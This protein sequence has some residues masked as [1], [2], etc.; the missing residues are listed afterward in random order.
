MTWTMLSECFTT[1]VFDNSSPNN[2]LQAATVPERAHR[3]ISCQKYTQTPNYLHLYKDVRIERC[4]F[5][6]NAFP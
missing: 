3:T 6:K 5:S 1:D 2:L 4:K